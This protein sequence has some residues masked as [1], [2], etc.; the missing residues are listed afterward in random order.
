MFN[1]RISQNTGTSDVDESVEYDA[2]ISYKHG[3]VDSAAARA[4]QRNLEHFHVPFLAEHTGRKISRIFLDEGELSATAAFSSHIQNALKNSRWLIIICSP[5]TK[6]SPWVNLEIETFIKYHDRNHILAVMTSGE[7]A[8]VFPDAFLGTGSFPDEMLAADARGDNLHEVLFKL[9]GDAL[10]RIAAPILETTYDGLKQRHRIY[11]LQRFSAASILCLALITGFL[12]Y[13][14]LQ[15]RKLAQFSR[16]L[17][18]RQSELI[19]NKASDLVESGDN[20]HAVRELLSLYAENASSGSILG[21]TFS[22][23]DI[24]PSAQYELTNALNLYTPEIQA[25]YLTESIA[26]DAIIQVPDELKP[27]L[28]SNNSFSYLLGA[29]RNRVYIWDINSLEL[30]NEFLFDETI[31]NWSSE[32]LY[33]DDKL[34]LCGKNSAA[35]YDILTGKVCWSANFLDEIC[36][37]ARSGTERAD[38]NTGEDK[39]YLL[40]SS[41]LTI[42]DTKSGSILS[43]TPLSIAESSSLDESSPVGTPQKAVLSSSGD[44]L[45]FSSNL[46]YKKSALYICDLATL[47]TVMVSSSDYIYDCYSDFTTYVFPNGEHI[48]FAQMDNSGKAKTCILNSVL[49]DQSAQSVEANGDADRSSFFLRNE[50]ST[51]YVLS[52]KHLRQFNAT[53]IAGSPV[54]IFA[55]FKKTDGDPLLAFGCF[56][57]L[58]LLDPADGTPRH[59]AAF[60]SCICNILQT[61]DTCFVF[62]MDGSLYLYDGNTSS[63]ITDAFPE[64]CADIERLNP[65]HIYFC[66]KNNNNITRYS[67]CKPDDSYTKMSA[68]QDVE[69]LPSNTL[70]QNENWTLLDGYDHL[71][72]I[73]ENGDRIQSASYPEL[74]TDPPNTTV[75][76]DALSE[77]TLRSNVHF[78]YLDGDTAHFIRSI[79][80]S[81]S[82]SSVTYRYQLNLADGSIKCAP[83]FRINSDGY[84]PTSTICDPSKH[85]LYLSQ[86]SDIAVIWEYELDTGKA[87]RHIL[88]FS[89]KY[90]I[91]GISPDGRKILTASDTDLSVVD[92]ESWSKD[93]SISLTGFSEDTINSICSEDSSEALFWN[94][95]ILVIPDKNSLHIFDSSGKEIQTITLARADVTDFDKV[96]K[97]AALSPDGEYLYYI[98]DQALVQYSLSKA[99]IVN[100][101]VLPKDTATDFTS[102]GDTSWKC[103]F[104]SSETENAQLSKIVDPAGLFTGKS[105]TH[106]NTIRILYNENFYCVRCDEDVFGLKT[107]VKDIKA[108]N[109]Q[110]GRLYFSLGISA[111]TFKYDQCYYREYSID[112]IIDIAQKRYG[113]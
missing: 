68:D 75:E 50:W 25:N 10:L 80:D 86:S 109:P 26:S 101:A 48:L 81:L 17:E 64:R 102:N 14:S 44:Y 47:N 11:R 33:G 34:I 3:P 74:F 73:S 98:D 91:A 21:D 77:L 58:V 2:F 71:Y 63:L 83:L 72:W 59:K 97:T 19:I 46:R 7:P 55:D 105:S 57:E 36:A 49:I 52:E 93:F 40:S 39:L 13:T 32:A 8:E 35:C 31:L 37:V 111:G 106:Y 82:N 103:W 99:G 61:A 45:L 70:G 112:E 41:S 24:P 79:G 29:G 20:C 85:I 6:K 12:L 84:S 92:L 23:S 107:W 100:K 104:S 4:L 54:S 96:Y 89:A 38:G 66:L 90:G 113:G 110:T 43:E 88:P 42:L 67:L 1:K 53:I 76:K 62:T 78:L 51:P 30:V 65:R 27:D 9:R 18:I 108:Y 69:Y 87:V 15:N 94:G 16:D 22:E 5:A 28:L 60:S 95:T 56:S